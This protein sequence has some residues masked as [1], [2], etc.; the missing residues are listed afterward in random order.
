MDTHDLTTAM[1]ASAP[2]GPLTLEHHQAIAVA[3]SRAKSIRAVAKVASFNGW[4]TGVFAAASFPFVL[5][6]LPA[7]LI[8]VGLGIVTYN[9][10]RGRRRLLQFDPTGPTF[11]GWN[12][13]ALF[14]MV[15]VYCLWTLGAELL[16]N[17]P[18]G[19]EL[20][21]HPELAAVLGSPQKLEH[22]HRMLTLTVYGAV[23]A[24]SAVFQGG[25][26]LYYFHRRKLVENFV[27][28]TPEWMLNLQRL[29]TV[30]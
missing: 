29:T 16:G 17:G 14:A 24:V 19:G 22:L 27:Q 8:T 18:L 2:D 4:S 10:F 13:L 3:H 26:A 28:E 20:A 25:C 30:D 7:L 6:S 5:S 23:I 21:A 9:E 15:T 12:Q 1:I 11:L